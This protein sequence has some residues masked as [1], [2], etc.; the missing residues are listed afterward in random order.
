MRFGQE[1]TPGNGPENYH[2][3]VS[4]ITAFLEQILPANIVTLDLRDIE[5]LVLEKL[6]PHTFF[7]DEAADQSEIFF[8]EYLYKAA[9]R[10]ETALLERAL[11]KDE[12]DN[13]RQGKIAS[14]LSNIRLGLLG[15]HANQIRLFGYINSGLEELAEVFPLAEE[16]SP[17][18]QTLERLGETLQPLM[19][20]YAAILF[21]DPPEW[22]IQE[23]KVKR[24][25]TTVGRLLP[26]DIWLH[27][28]YSNQLSQERHALALQISDTQH[29]EELE[30]EVEHYHQEI[31][32]SLLLEMP[33]HPDDALHRE[34]CTTIASITT[35]LIWLE[36]GRRDI[37]MRE[38]GPL[39]VT[40]DGYVE[41]GI[42]EKKSLDDILDSIELLTSEE[43]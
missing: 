37:F 1:P 21:P 24:I 38:I 15:L 43:F 20:Q 40:L 19:G 7:N 35:S 13:I 25:K 12:A 33:G 23:L 14:A 30:T 2:E 5:P 8:E 10:I 39:L 32:Q 16:G 3:A 34:Y 42:V 26:N 4:Q 18:H 31:L 22:Q 27:E 28:V 36:G 6:T 29:P 11:P 9:G 17:I 41:R